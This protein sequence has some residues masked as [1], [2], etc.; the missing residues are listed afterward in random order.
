MDHYPDIGGGQKT[1]L[2]YLANFPKKNINCYVVCGHEEGSFTKELQK[3]DLPVFKVRFNESNIRINRTSENTKIRKDFPYFLSNLPLFVKSSFKIAKIIKI[4]NID[5]IYANTTKTACF[6][7]FASMLTSKPLIYRAS[8]D[9]FFSNHGWIDY[10]VCNQTKKILACSDF[11]ASS[12]K[13]WFWKVKTVYPPID[14]EELTR[15]L[16]KESIDKIRKQYRISNNAFVVVQI[17]CLRRVKRHVDL[18]L[19]TAQIIKSGNPRIMLLFVGSDSQGK[20]INIKRELIKIAKEL[21]IWKHIIFTGYKKDVGSIL[22]ASDL[23]VVP[24]LTE[25]FGRV[26]VEALYLEVPVIASNTGAI[27]EIIKN[28]ETGYLFEPQNVKALK[29]C[30]R[31]VLENYNKAKQL[32][33]KGR[34]YVK[35][36]FSLESVLKKNIDIFSELVT[37]R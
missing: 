24:S 30:I 37:K 6:G 25:T 13:E 3:L 10:V 23:L 33:Q 17:G 14:F 1:L 11:V 8:N 7:A 2:T 31:K 27:P 9:R 16:S 4:N 15:N 29:D 5:I 34:R 22:K 35:I 18:L 26:I 32:A 19:S 20:E 21:N 12:F 28:G 36:R